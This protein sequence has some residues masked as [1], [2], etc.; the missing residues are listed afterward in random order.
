MQNNDQH[1]DF[2]AAFDQF[3]GQSEQAP[4]TAAAP[5]ENAPPAVDD[6]APADQG[7]V[8]AV[9]GSD[10]AAQQQP[11]PADDLLASLPENLRPTVQ[12]LIQERDQ[13]KHR[14]LSDAGRLGA[15]T[16]KLNQ[17]QAAQQ[18]A[19]ANPTAPAAAQ[20][21]AS[22]KHLDELRET[23][24]ELAAALEQDAAARQQ[25][26]AQLRQEAEAPVRQLQHE[27]YLTSQF[28]AL[29]AA[30][31][32]WQRVVQQAE[33][34]Q[35]LQKQPATI[36]SMMQSDDASE[37]TWLLDQ[38]KQH[39]QQARQA[40]A[41]IRDQQ[42]QRLQQGVAVTSKGVPASSAPPEDFDSAFDYFSRRA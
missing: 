12:N 23:F 42:R 22:N 30:H 33:F 25:E 32:D 1:E 41:A 4:A 6:P 11:A 17:L 24:P 34:G 10:A 39:H 18:A 35:W 38:F 9:P 21:A 20:S 28:A 37:A 27:Q 29:E 40:S 13:F 3:A 15:L 26:M 7:T 8:Q 19:A 5:P 16:R 14:A 36:Q 2:D 31:P